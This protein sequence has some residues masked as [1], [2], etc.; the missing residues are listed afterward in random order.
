MLSA[1]E[2]SRRLSESDPRLPDLPVV[3]DDDLRAEA[4]GAP[5][6]IERIR[7][8]PGTA[9]VAAVRGPDGPVWIASY[10]APDKL[11]KTRRRAAVVRG[12]VRQ[13]SAVTMTGPAHADRLLAPRVRRLLEAEP[14]LL[15]ESAVLRYNP[16]RRL[17]LRWRG[18]AL[19]IAAGDDGTG[20]E[21]A[22]RL[23]RAGMPVLPP[24]RVQKGA[25]STP[26]WGDG[27]LSTRPD[28]E[29]ERRAGAALAAVHSASLGAVAP[30]AVDPAER[31]RCAADAVA[32]LLP[33]LEARAT[34]VARRLAALLTDPERVVAHG[35][36]S[37]D[38]VLTDGRSVRLI[39]F[40]RAVSA[41]AALDLGS[42]LAAG[43]TQAL[44]DGYREAGG[45]AD[46]R[47]VRSWQ[48]LAQLQ[49]AAEPFRT[50]HPDWPARTTAALES[51]EELLT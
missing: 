17:L 29:L 47:A 1:A 35:D 37:P 32:I 10:A 49:R 3:L 13:L 48:A 44:I 30:P 36:L 16:H 22:A 27:D 46:P 38:Q 41:P 20:A 50:G 11:E 4:L 24:R 39:D 25:T 40:D 19:K 14:A 23:A 9:V 43:G 26:W 21:V 45:R 15:R 18:H 42:H 6:A 33:E 28:A 12:G 8:K 31:A 5:S 7:Y 2:A 51:A 34:R